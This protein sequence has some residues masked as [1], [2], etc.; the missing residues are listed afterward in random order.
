MKRPWHGELPRGFTVVEL[1]VVIAIISILAA[2]LLPVLNQA[3]SRA[4]R[5]A[6]VSQLREVGQAAHVFANDHRGQLPMQVPVRDGGSEEFT[7]AT[8]NFTSRHYQSLSNELATPQLLVCPADTLLSARSFAALQN[9]NVSYFVN[10]R[11]EHGQA[12]SILAGDRNLT[13]DRL[14]ALTVLPLGANSPLRWTHELHRFKGNIVF[15]DAHVELFS[16]PTLAIPTGNSLAEAQLAMPPGPTTAA[17]TALNYS[18]APAPVSAERP[19]PAM[20]LGSPAAPARAQKG[21]A[22]SQN[23]THTGSGSLPQ[24]V[25]EQVSAQ[26]A[27]L[28]MVSTN[29]PAG[30]AGGATEEAMM[31]SQFDSQVVSFLQGLIKWTY[32]LVLLLLLLYLAWRFYIWRAG[33]GRRREANIHPNRMP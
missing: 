25:S 23:S 30:G 11:A 16:G 17:P 5:I 22:N 13:S 8:G 21:T 32:L 10:V 4:K 7:H 12:T 18:Q 27:T 1:L 6:C 20:S 29:T 26:K 2:L 31:L 9:T 19:L 33:R 3:K 24:D 14:G 28:P 15:N